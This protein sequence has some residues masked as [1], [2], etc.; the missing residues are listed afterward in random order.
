MNAITFEP[1]RSM[2]NNDDFFKKV[3][4]ISN[5]VASFCKAIH[6]RFT[7][8]ETLVAI[9]EGAAP[10]ALQTALSGGLNA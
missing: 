4:N 6:K 9:S 10:L 3:D 5:L 7:K 1:G 8:V 2:G